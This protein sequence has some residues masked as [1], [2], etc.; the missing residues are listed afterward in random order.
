[1]YPGKKNGNNPSYGLF[2]FYINITEM[3]SGLNESLADLR[4]DIVQHRNRDGD[5]PYGQASCFVLELSNPLDE[6]EAN[7]TTTH[8]ADHRG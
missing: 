4:T 3:V 2:P 7:P 6:D 8:Q 1:M 5:Q